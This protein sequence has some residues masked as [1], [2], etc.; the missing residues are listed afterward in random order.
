MLLPHCLAIKQNV[1]WRFCLSEKD[2]LLIFPILYHG[3]GRFG[4]L[5][6]HSRIS[7]GDEFIKYNDFR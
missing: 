6:C 4:T 3:N 5:G 7:I 2:L 1:S